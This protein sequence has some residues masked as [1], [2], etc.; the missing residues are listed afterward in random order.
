VAQSTIYD[1]NAGGDVAANLQLAEDGL[2]GF[3]VRGRK[4]QRWAYSEIE[5]AFAA[6][7]RSD[8]VLIRR[9][10]PEIRL[11]LEEAAVYESLA[12]RAPQLRPR[13]SLSFLALWAGV[14]EQAQ[15][16]VLLFLIFGLPLLLYSI[17]AGWFH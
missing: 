1:P 15:T 9:G 6:N 7:A 4:L 16:T 13:R 17:V 2:Y 11:H 8:H 10:R 5:H 3:D 14:P 12:L